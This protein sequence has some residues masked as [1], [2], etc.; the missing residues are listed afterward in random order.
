[1]ACRQ[2]SRAQLRHLYLRGELLSYRLNTIHNLRHLVR[3]LEAARA[4]IMDGNFP[5]FRRERLSQ[6]TPL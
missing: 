1:V 5:R 4:A 2:H 3:L 6:P